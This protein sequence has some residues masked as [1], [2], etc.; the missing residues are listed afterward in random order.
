M[1]TL[2]TIA[3]TLLF[4][5]GMLSCEIDPNK[6][7]P[8]IPSKGTPTEIGK[9]LGATT[10][11]MIGAQGG[12][13]ST[14][15]G[16]L[17]L[18]FPAGALTKETNITIRPVENKAWGGVG[19]GYEFGP[20]SSE[21]AKPISFTYKYNDKEMSG[22]SLDNMALAFQ[23]QNKIWQ[24]TSPL[25]VDKTRKKI[26]GYLKHFSWW[27][28]ITRYQLLPEYDTVQVKEIKELRLEHLD[29]GFEWPWTDNPNP[30]PE[31]ALLVPL[32]TPKL[33]DRTDIAKLYLNGVDWT[34]KEPKDQTSGTLGYASSG[35]KAVVIYTAPGKKPEAA[36]NPVAI[37]VEL[38]HA[39]KA[40]LLLVSNLYINTE[41][42]FSVD[43]SDPSEIV[44]YAA[45]GDGELYLNFEDNMSNTLNVYTKNFKEGKFSFNTSETYIGAVHKSKEK[46]GSS[47]YK[48]CKKTMSESGSVVIEK[49]YKSEGKTYLKGQIIGTVCTKHQADE[50]CNV[51]VH[52]TMKVFANFTTIVSAI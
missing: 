43:G 19:I 38:Q 12:S 41:N 10:A 17:T 33:A 16:K 29:N 37:S 25:S 32:N 23:D 49:L 11:K 51:V 36:Y 9:P 45:G 27:S 40:K 50:H 52:E 1:K 34:T 6:P 2:Q 42:T 39:G 30:S 26:S 7:E 46:Q 24:M 14:P 18:N 31:I 28:M 22:V 8:G 21:F 48:H 4:S 44:I 5:A 20:D 13:I 47:I 3:I 15:D 35:N